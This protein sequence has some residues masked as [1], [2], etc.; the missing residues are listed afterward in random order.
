MDPPFQNQDYKS[1]TPLSKIKTTI[2]LTT[3]QLQVEQVYMA[4]PVV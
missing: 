2:Q 4:M 1:M 3:Y